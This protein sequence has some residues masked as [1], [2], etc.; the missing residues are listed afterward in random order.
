M[1]PRSPFNVVGAPNVHRFVVEVGP[2]DLVDKE[3]LLGIEYGERCCIPLGLLRSRRWVVSYFVLRFVRAGVGD[4]WEVRG[5]MSEVRVTAPWAEGPWF[6]S[7]SFRAREGGDW[8]WAA[9][10][11]QDF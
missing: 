6:F 9:V 5:Q 3:G 11:A 10:N 1:L 2:E 7:Y 4:V 8:R